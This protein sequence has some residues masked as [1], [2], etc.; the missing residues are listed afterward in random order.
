MKEN[1][2]EWLLTEPSSTSSLRIYH[3]D[4]GSPPSSNPSNTITFGLGLMKLTSPVELEA[5]AS[6]VLT[7]SA[8]IWASKER[9]GREGLLYSALPTCS[10]MSG[11]ET[12]SWSTIV[13]MRKCFLIPPTNAASK[14]KAGGQEI[15][16]IAQ[17]GYHLLYC[18]LS[19][20]CRP[21]HPQKLS[22]SINIFD[23]VHDLLQNGLSCVCVA[24]W[25]S[26][27]SS[28]LCKAPGTIFFWRSLIPVY[29]LEIWRHKN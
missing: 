18:R 17:L 21:M 9:V 15:H 29:S 14:K 12:M 19:S 24:F 27:R 5:A 2:M 23:R 13:V 22:L 25:R 10:W 6:R 11:I 16:L 28:E 1:G 7:I 8:S 26:Y 4:S 3:W 20:S